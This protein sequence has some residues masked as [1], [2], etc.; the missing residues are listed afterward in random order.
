[1]RLPRV[2]GCLLACACLAAPC[3]AW[4]SKEGEILYPEHRFHYAYPS[5]DV[6]IERA[7]GSEYG[8]RQN[9][10]STASIRDHPYWTSEP[11]ESDFPLYSNGLHVFLRLK[12]PKDEHG[13]NYWSFIA[14]IADDQSYGVLWERSHHRTA[15][16]GLVH[17]WKHMEWAGGNDA[18]GDEWPIFVFYEG[19]YAELQVQREIRTI[20][21]CY[22]VSHLRVDGAGEEYIGDIDVYIGSGTDTSG[23]KLEFKQ[24]TINFSVDMKIVSGKPVF[25]WH[26]GPQR[27]KWRTDPVH[28]TYHQDKWRT[29]LRERTDSP[30][31]VVEPE[32]SFFVLV[33][34]P[35]RGI[36]AA[37]TTSIVD[38]KT[39]PKQRKLGQR[40]KPLQIK[41]SF[42]AK[43]RRHQGFVTY[44]NRAFWFY[45]EPFKVKAKLDVPED[46]RPLLAAWVVNFPSGIA[47]RARPGVWVEARGSRK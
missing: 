30:P 34:D 14:A 31:K 1:M 24:R 29:E 40:P 38:W 42:A 16:W 12:P 8:I 37:E 9:V 45:C 18:M 22:R 46:L 10:V 28:R 20:S 7:Q 44:R 26:R 36:R 4:Q 19:L 25:E 6:V 11:R 2:T 35:V 47:R 15:R 23:K 32:S 43:R 39:W 13:T 17:S 41:K 21:K 3:S 27:G 33:G 5:G